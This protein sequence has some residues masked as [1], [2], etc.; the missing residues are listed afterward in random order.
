MIKTI[1]DVNKIFESDS[2]I[3]LEALQQLLFNNVTTKKVYTVQV[4]CY[5]LFYFCAIFWQKRIVGFI[6]KYFDLFKSSSTSVLIFALN[7]LGSDPRARF[8]KTMNVVSR[9][10]GFLKIPTHFA[11]KN[12]RKRVL[13]PE[14]LLKLQ[15]NLLPAFA[16][17]RIRAVFV[18]L[19]TLYNVNGPT[20]DK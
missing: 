18:T 3:F 17:P 6:F 2:E 8:T 20:Q 15:Q 5:Y 7:Q 12:S 9:H 19:Q 4:L 11:I 16:L 14:K 1:L 13:L 10:H